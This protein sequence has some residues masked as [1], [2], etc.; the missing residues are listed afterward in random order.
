MRAAASDTLR[1]LPRAAGVLPRAALRLPPVFR[2]RLILFVVLAGALAGGYYGWLRDSSLVRV[3]R[4]RVDGLS[5]PG[6]RRVR[7]ALVQSARGMTTLHV[8]PAELERAVATEP[9]VHSISVQTKFPHGVRIEVVQNTPVAV[10]VVGGRRVPV[11]ADGTLLPETRPSASLPTIAAGALPTGMRLGNGRSLRLVEVAAGAPAPLR[12]RLVSIGQTAA[13]GYVA[14]VRGGPPIWLGD[15]SE[16]ELKWT[17]ATAILA[18]QSSDGAGWIDVRI[19]E[20]A[21]VGGLAQ[22]ALSAADV[23]AAS[24]PAAPVVPA[25][26]AAAAPATTAQT[27]APAASTPAPQAAPQQA[28]AQPTAPAQQAQ[29]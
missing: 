19:P 14:M 8:R 22:G 25:A 11:A 26:P 16:L 9:L 29:P 13:H 10:L 5:G 2:R 6:S 12:R 24:A 15:L 18:Q 7:A 4:V 27:P 21:V 3:E 20:R 23:A 17:A 1:L 28:Q